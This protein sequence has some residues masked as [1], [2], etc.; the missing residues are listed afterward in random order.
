MT[1]ILCVY[2]QSCPTLC[3][4]MDCSPPGSSVHGI[5]QARTLEWVPFLPPGDLPDLG[6]NLCLLY[7]Q[8]KS[9]PLSYLDRGMISTYI[10]SG[11]KRTMLKD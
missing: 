3:N 10:I 5:S 4:S 9:L 6:L 11:P 1:L 7:W 8:A 2:A